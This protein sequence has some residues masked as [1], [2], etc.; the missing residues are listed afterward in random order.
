MTTATVSILIPV[1]NAA[2]ML[3]ETLDTA[4]A[5]AASVDAEIIALDDGSTDRSV[6]VLKARG[7]ALRY[8]TQSNRGVSVTRNTLAKSATGEWLLFLD[9]D[10]LL[11]PGT[12]RAR[13]ALATDSCDGVYCDWRRFSGDGKGRHWGETVARSI[14]SVHAD[15]T[16]ALFAGFWSPPVAW[17]WRRSLHK[18]IGGFR[19][20][21]PVIQDARYALDAALAGARLLHAPHLGGGYREAQ[22]HSLSRRDD[23][24]FARDCLMHAGQ[25]EAVYRA[26]GELTVDQQ[27]ALATTYEFAARKLA[28]HAPESAA[29]AMRLALMHQPGR[30]SRWLRAAD[31]M[32][33][34]FGDRSGLSMVSLA[35][36]FGQGAA[37]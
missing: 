11:L 8:S 24:R 15:P 17:L 19:E 30:P 2:A 4:I 34:L 6:E 32:S 25:V 29:I 12:L 18:A 26:R 37:R 28:A 14:E 5:E 3:D 16:V 1:Y 27:R 33:R 9:A 20:D 23:T 22:A 21:L 36:R 7:S 13:L 10:D 35:T 31:R